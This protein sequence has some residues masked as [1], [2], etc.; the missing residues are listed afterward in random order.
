MKTSISTKI[1]NLFRPLIKNWKKAII[2]VIGVGSL[3]WFLVRV[4][5]KPSRASYPCMRV[6]APLASSFVLWIIGLVVS[7]TAFKKMRTAFAKSSYIYGILFLLVGTSFAIFTA[8]QSGLISFADTQVETVIPNNPIGEA[9]G[10]FPGRVVWV[11]NPDA[12]NENCTNTCDYDNTTGDE[13]DDGWFLDKNNNQ[14]VIDNMVSTAIQQITGETTDLAAWQRIFTRFNEQKHG[15][16]EGY[17]AGQKVYIKVNVTSAYSKGSFWGNISD[18][19]NVMENSCYGTAETSPHVA[20]SLLRQLINVYEIPQD[21]IYIGDPMKSIYNHSYNKWHAEFPDIHYVDCDG[22]YGREKAIPTTAAVLKYSDK[23]TELEYA[24]DKIYKQMNEADY[25]FNLPTLKAHARAGITVFAKNHFGS[26]TRESAFHLHGG[27]VAPNEGAPTRTASNLYR[28]QV[29]LMGHE[30]LGGN[31]VLFLLDAIY[32]GSEA[33]DPPTKWD[34][35]PFNHDWTS[36]IF[37]SFD[38]VAIESVSFDF[39]NTEYNG[40]NGKVNYPTM[41]GT[42]DYLRQAASSEYWPAGFT[43]DPEDD[44]TPISSLGVNEHWNN[45]TNKQY[46]RNLGTGNGIELVFIDQ[47]TTDI[48]DNTNGTTPENFTLNQNYPNPFNPST[49]ISFSLNENASVK[50]EVLDVLGNFIDELY[51]GDKAA[52]TYS[53]N[54]NG[55]D[56]SGRKVSSGNYI[57]RLTKTSGTSS[58]VLT[59]K[60]TL[61]K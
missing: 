39:L 1:T 54:W 29:D 49:T 61:L 25:L 22:T 45:S 55:T 8:S 4:I 32:A 35:A 17:V 12:T 42:T 6:A 30:R 18:D 31:T 41:Q 59:K 36:S 28:T 16:S 33:I 3:I 56:N 34:M 24:T 43:Y 53:F 52:G 46:T 5:P 13:D 20:L 14:E 50:L 37:V 60:M 2:P 23:G 48:D 27:L 44:G 58:S 57:Y 19:N 40:Q 7:I 11:W 47:S 15:R 26:N 51:S 21:A 38:P 9:K 10:I